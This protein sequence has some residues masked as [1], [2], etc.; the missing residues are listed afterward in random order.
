[1]NRRPFRGRGLP[2]G[3][4]DGAVL[5]LGPYPPAYRAAGVERI[6]PQQYLDEV[7][8]VLPYWPKE[9]HL[10]ILASRP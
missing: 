10:E 7:L 6:D 4:T 5:P 3:P 9:R 8:R 1:M 2:T